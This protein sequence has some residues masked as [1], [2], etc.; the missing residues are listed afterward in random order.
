VANIARPP[1]FV[2]E[3]RS[4][5]EQCVW[6]AAIR[7]YDCGATS[8][9]SAGGRVRANFPAHVKQVTFGACESAT[10]SRRTT[11]GEQRI[12][13][14]FVLCGLI[15]LAAHSA[16]AV[17]LKVGDR[18]P[19]VSGEEIIVRNDGGLQRQGQVLN[20]GQVCHVNG[21]TKNWL[22]VRR[23]VAS[24]TLLE[25]VGPSP[26]DEPIIDY[27]SSL[28][29]EC[30]LGTETTRPLTEMRARFNEY[31]KETDLQLIKSLSG[32]PTNSL[33]DVT[34]VTSVPKG[35]TR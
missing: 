25:L 6:T 35:Q 10:Q 30:P 12:V 3:V 13:W 24:W 20:F 23:I 22:L 19:A 18:V 4:L 14:K 31:A 33:V 8:D 7:P 26:G 11:C 15:A 16:K 28:A 34:A 2:R 17:E 29:A 1:W 32:S 9:G 5:S 27:P 21:W